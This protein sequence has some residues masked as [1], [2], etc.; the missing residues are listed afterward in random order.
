MTTLL[1]LSRHV[2][3]IESLRHE[4]GKQVSEAGWTGW[5]RTNIQNLR[6]LDSVIKESMRDGNRD[7]VVYDKPDEWDGF[8]YYKMRQA[9]DKEDMAQLACATVEHAGFGVG[10]HSCPGRFYASD[11]IKIILCHILMKYDWKVVDNGSPETVVVAWTQMV[12]PDVKI[13]FKRR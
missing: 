12:H 7:P 10:K 5:N 8:R 1:D 6:L 11:L 13:L 9:G 4:I 2:D 3:V